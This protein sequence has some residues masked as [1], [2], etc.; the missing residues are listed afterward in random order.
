[1][2]CTDRMCFQDSTVRSEVVHDVRSKVREVIGRIEGGGIYMLRVA[3]RPEICVC[4]LERMPF[5]DWTG[6]QLA[7]WL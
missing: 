1:M 2:R 6:I 5:Y 3:F 7:V 4:C